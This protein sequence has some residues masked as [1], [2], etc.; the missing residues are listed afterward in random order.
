MF[1]NRT[2]VT[3][4]SF[5]LTLDGVTVFAYDLPMIVYWLVGFI[6]GLP[7]TVRPN[8]LVRSP[9]TGMVSFSCCFATSSPYETLF[10]PPDTMPCFTDSCCLSTP[11]ALA[12]R[13]RRAWYV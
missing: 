6:G 12:A 1:G 2:S 11:S 4:V 7:V 3:Q 9:V 5:A 8:M 13:S 10:P